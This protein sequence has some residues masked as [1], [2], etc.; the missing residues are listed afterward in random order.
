[1][2]KAKSTTLAL[3]IVIGLCMIPAPLVAEITDEVQRVLTIIMGEKKDF[4]QRE[5]RLSP[6]TAEEFWPVYESYQEELKGINEDYIL[7]IW[8]RIEGAGILNSDKAETTIKEY[9]EIER[10]KLKLKE[11]YLQEFSKVLPP[12]KLLRYYQLE[13]RAKTF[14]DSKLSKKIPLLE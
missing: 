7:F 12:G 3:T 9:F 5:M 13:T 4:V 11:S 2:M 10:S 6:E 8:S 1:M 14:I